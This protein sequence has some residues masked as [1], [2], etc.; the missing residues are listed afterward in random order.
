MVAKA[1][2]SDKGTK[3]LNLNFFFIYPITNNSYNGWL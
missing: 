2:A 3:F 1:G